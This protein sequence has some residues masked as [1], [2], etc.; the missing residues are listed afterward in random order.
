MVVMITIHNPIY[1]LKPVN[2]ALIETR[3]AP[4]IPIKKSLLVA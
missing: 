2:V 1:T 3:L 4:K